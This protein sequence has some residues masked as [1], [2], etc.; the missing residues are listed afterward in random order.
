MFGSKPALAQR[1]FILSWSIYVSFKMIRGSSFISENETSFL[2]AKGWFLWTT[3]TLSDMNT[4]VILKSWEENGRMTTPISIS[5]FSTLSFTVLAPASIT[6]RLILGYI[7]LNS[8]IVDV[9]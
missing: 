7:F 8:C 1:A 2:E 5:P 9:K 6:L 3:T 4:E